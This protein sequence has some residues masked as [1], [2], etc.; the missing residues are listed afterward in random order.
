MMTT[1]AAWFIWAVSIVAPLIAAMSVRSTI[2]QSNRRLYYEWYQLSNKY[3]WRYDK[4]QEPPKPEYEKNPL[5]IKCVFWYV[6]VSSATII[7]W[8]ISTVVMG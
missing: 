5:W 2:N 1:D 6:G 8:A 3:E 4:K 7:I